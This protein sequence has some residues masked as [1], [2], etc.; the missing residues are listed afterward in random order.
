MDSKCGL[1]FLVAS[2]WDSAPLKYISRLTHR[3]HGHGHMCTQK[4][5]LFYSNCFVSQQKIC[6]EILQI[7]Y[8]MLHSK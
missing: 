8:F 5:V 6:F 1:H 2:V 3:S 7:F 4:N